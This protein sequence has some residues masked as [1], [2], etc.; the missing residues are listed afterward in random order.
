MCSCWKSTSKRRPLR[1]RTRPVSTGAGVGSS[2]GATVIGS[3][4]APLGACPLVSMA[5][6][7]LSKHEGASFYEIIK[8]NFAA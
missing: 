1:T 5:T 8:P 6:P 3:S 7:E 2:A 4:P